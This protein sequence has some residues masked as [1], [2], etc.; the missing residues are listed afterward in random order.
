MPC[1]LVDNFDSTGPDDPFVMIGME[2]L[3]DLP[4]KGRFII[5]Q[6][7]KTDRAGR[8]RLLHDVAHHR[9]YRGRIYTSTKKS[10]QR[11]L[12][13]QS[14]TGGFAKLV[15]QQLTPLLLAPVL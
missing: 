3:R 6:L 5:L 2:L 13:H 10:T 8:Y 1:K 14:N 9:H 4:G 12:A 15:S 7:V 11:D